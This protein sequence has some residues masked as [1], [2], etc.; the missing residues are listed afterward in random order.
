MVGDGSLHHPD[1]LRPPRLGQGDAQAAL[2]VNLDKIVDVGKG[3]LGVV[4][5]HALAA[6]G[7]GGRD[8]RLRQEPGR[9]GL[10]TARRVADADMGLGGVAILEELRDEAF[11]AG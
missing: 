2:G 5:G 11:V 6:D 4:L 3:D 1:A 7:D 10:R 8:L 9:A